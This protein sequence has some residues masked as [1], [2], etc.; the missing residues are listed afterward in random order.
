MGGLGNRL[1]IGAAAKRIQSQTGIDVELISVLPDARLGTWREGGLVENPALT[2]RPLSQVSRAQRLSLSLSRQISQWAN[3]RSV[4]IAKTWV[5]ER[6]RVSTWEIPPNAN[7]CASYFQSIPDLADSIRSLILEPIRSKGAPRVDALAG[8]C[9]GRELT[10][11]VR[12]GDFIASHRHKPLTTCYYLQAVDLL[13][14]KDWDRVVILNN[15]PNLAQKVR[16]ALKS[17]MSPRVQVYLENVDFRLNEREA[18]RYMSHAGDLITSNS[19]LSKIAGLM[20]ES[21]GARNIV[22][23][24]SKHDAGPIPRSWLRVQMPCKSERK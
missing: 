21:L 23:L 7:L 17:S 4:S 20:A 19:T 6:S 18:L 9:G 3:G 24:D 5:A 8:D 14:F 1:F 2:L 16:E 11:H 15:D 13:G 10:V 22:G 12:G